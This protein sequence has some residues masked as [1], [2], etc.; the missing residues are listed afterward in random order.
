M[1]ASSLTQGLRSASG[2][3]LS[4]SQ[5]VKQKIAHNYVCEPPGILETVDYHNN[6]EQKKVYSGKNSRSHKCYSLQVDIIQEGRRQLGMNWDEK[7]RR[8][9]NRKR[10]RFSKK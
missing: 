9:K 1:E 6:K 5:K 3:V 10:R 7:R 8:R 4:W 2:S